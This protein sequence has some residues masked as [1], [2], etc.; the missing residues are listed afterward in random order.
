VLDPDEFAL[1]KQHTYKSA[2]PPELAW[3]YLEQNRG[4][5]FD[6][7][8]VDAFQQA[9]ADAEEIRAAYPDGEGAQQRQGFGASA[10]AADGL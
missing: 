3:N 6:P 8:C 5:R 10:A 9:Q 1:I 7:A 2:W 4:T